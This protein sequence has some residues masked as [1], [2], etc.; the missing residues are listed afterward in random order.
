[1]KFIKGS[2][3]LFNMAEGLRFRGFNF[4]NDIRR[5][6]LFGEGPYQGWGPFFYG[7]VFDLSPG[8]I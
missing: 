8:K 1:M 4:C 5:A 2:G 7:G 6:I 3:E